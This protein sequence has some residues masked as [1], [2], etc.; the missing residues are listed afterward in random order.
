M[1]HFNR[2]RA[3]SEARSEIQAEIPGLTAGGATSSLST[4]GRW[5]LPPSATAPGV[6]PPSAHRLHNRTHQGGA[7]YARTPKMELF[8]LSVANM[9][10]HHTFYE[11]AAARDKR[12]AQLVRKLAV[13]DPE[14]T[15]GLLG[16]L[17]T[18]AHMRTAS[19]V[20]AAEFVRARLD[21][22]AVGFS[23]Q[24]VS[25]VLQRADEPGELL[26]YW[27][28]RHG[29]RIPQPLKR[30][31][32]DAARRLYTGRALLKYDT[33]SH[34]YRFGDVIE[35]THPSP[36]PRRPWQ[37]D[38]F[39]YAIDRRHHPD[40]ALPPSGATL[41]AAHRELMAVPVEERRP[42]VTAPGGSER[43][44]AA[45]MTWE[46]V[47]G[48]LQGPLDA[49]VWEALIPS[50]GAMAL[51]RNLRNLDQAGVSDRAA[52]EVAARISCPDEVRRSRQFPFRYLAAHRNA[53]SR[54][55]EEALE[56][57]L[58]HSLANVPELPGRTLIL[59][60]RSGSMFDRPSEH[61]QL[62]RADSAAI[63]GTALAHRAARADLVE[64]GSDSRRV[65]LAPGEPVLRVLDR[66][67]D[68]G[69]TNTALALRRH[70]DR[71][72]RVVMVTDEQAG[73]S[74]WS[75]PLRAIPLRIPVYTWNLAGYAPAHAP[76]GPHHHTFGGL[77]DAAFRLIPL[78][79]VGKDSKWPWE[80]RSSA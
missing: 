8:L 54:R 49:A 28:S 43:L 44:N 13:S 25:A 46:S 26:A 73:P 69:G 32:A 75:N 12:Y 22:G 5:L 37:G 40:R 18:E 57:A 77:S 58:G 14:W 68:L 74:Q 1:P 23:R 36:D 62:N 15:L 21:A 3:K 56:T 20:G 61:T 71:H 65:E 35:L 80:T 24:A 59:V 2:Q 51:V 6:R 4:H 63:F 53:P 41:L 10:G 70:Y 45:G 76:S 17:R 79:E 31:I 39:K 72:D 19:L 29:R 55:W 9:V 48:W 67:H 42:L 30:G 78:I 34:P 66:F 33:A 38:L 7:A 47:A 11:D 52:A 64:F 60:D 16:W 50:M 27:T